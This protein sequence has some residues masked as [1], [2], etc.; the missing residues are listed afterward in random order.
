MKCVC[1]MH[2]FVV[3]LQHYLSMEYYILLYYVWNIV[4]KFRMVSQ[5]KMSSLTFQ[6]DIDA[7]QA[8]FHGYICLDLLPETGSVLSYSLHRGHLPFLTKVYHCK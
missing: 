3:A 6:G 1:R 7:P 8:Y 5:C 2:I 4:Y